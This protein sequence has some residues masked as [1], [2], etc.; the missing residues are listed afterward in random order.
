M[1]ARLFTLIFAFCA[2]ESSANELPEWRPDGTVAAWTRVGGTISAWPNDSALLTRTPALK[3]FD[4]DGREWMEFDYAYFAPTLSPRCEAWKARPLPSGLSVDEHLRS[5]M[6][7]AE[8]EHAMNEDA[9]CVRR[10]RAWI[11]EDR[12]R[13]WAPPKNIGTLKKLPQAEELERGFDFL[14]LRH[15]TQQILGAD[16]AATDL[17]AP[18]IGAC[19][20]TPKQ[21]N[22]LKPRNG[23]GYDRHF[24]PHWERARQASIRLPSG[25][26][27]DN[28]DL[29]AIDAVARTLYG[30]VQGCQFDWKEDEYRPGHF[31]AVGRLIADRSEAVGS[32]THGG[33]RDF[34][35]PSELPIM[36]Q[37]VSRSGQFNNW[38]LAI[39]N[40]RGRPYKLNGALFNSLCPR[41][42]RNKN[43]FVGPAERLSEE[44]EEIWKW[45]VEIAAQMY[46]NRPVYQALY[47]WKIAGRPKPD[48]RVLFF[49]HGDTKPSSRYS[50]FQ[51]LAVEGVGPYRLEYPKQCALLKTWKA[52]P[53]SR[54]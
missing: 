39:K 35:Q 20:V 41:N 37:V 24:A 15:L 52:V 6:S 26:V 14:H 42:E 12:L 7:L 16:A 5:A 23:S 21:W 48:L 3:V 54:L 44:H 22:K 25:R 10:G 31:E 30:E 51:P 1:I 36:E 18:H 17:I 34:G 2:L 33:T 8:L 49:T 11:R 45:A 40:R 29:R 46:L 43:V 47:P 27:L 28:R 19:I 9:D 32:G 50:K 13:P 4:R 53:K 38:D